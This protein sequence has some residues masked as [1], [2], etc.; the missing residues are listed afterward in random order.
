MATNLEKYKTDLDNLIKTGDDIL[1]DFYKNKE[2]SKFSVLYHRWYTESREVIKWLIPNRLDEFEKLYK[3]EKRKSIDSSSYTIQDWLLGIRAPVDEFTGQKRFE[4]F[5]AAIMRFQNQLLILKSARARFESSL[6]DIKQLVQA[7]LFDSELDA[8]RELNKKGFTRGAGAIAGVVLE[9]H[10]AQVCENHNI[11]IRK[12]NPSINDYNQ[13]L[14][15]NEVIDIKDWRF[16]QHLA[17][18]RN[19]CDHKKKKEPTKEDIE[20]L[21]KGVEKITKTIF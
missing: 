4:D 21:I 11:K 3:P 18:L 15:D 1:D 8:A 13:L 7:D 14:K 9:G 20:E 10:L 5:G 19:L 16:I 12:K 17:D 6:F 2:K